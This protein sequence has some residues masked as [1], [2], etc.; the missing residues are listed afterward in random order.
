[1]RKCSGKVNG[2]ADGAWGVRH[3]NNEEEQS[4]RLLLFFTLIIIG[5][6]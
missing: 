3:E 4:L 6:I 5:F 2:N 1:M